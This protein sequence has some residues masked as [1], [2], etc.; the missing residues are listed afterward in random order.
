MNGEEF[1]ESACWY[2]IHTKPKQ[3][4]R[5]ESNLRAWR[6]E[7]F[8]PRV[9]ERCLGRV[10]GTAAYHIKPLFPRYIFAHFKASNML[11]KICFTRGVS[12]V[13]GFGGG[14][15]PV[16]NEIISYIKSQAAED[17]FIRIGEELKAG[18]KVIISDGPFQELTGIFE[19]EMKDSNRVRILLTTIKYQSHVM[20]DK[21]A[22]RK[23]GASA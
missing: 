13:V 10:A 5:A 12:R 19:R 11:H 2:A 15:T 3:E 20:I 7:T 1:A 6:V 14:P 9:K 8:V 16:E 21:A 18:D 17:G 23:L 22:V 4:D